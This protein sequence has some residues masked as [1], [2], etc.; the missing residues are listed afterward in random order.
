MSDLISIFQE[1][2]Q[3]R[4]RFIEARLDGENLR[5]ALKK[6]LVD[7]CI[8]DPAAELCMIWLKARI[9]AGMEPLADLPSTLVAQVFAGQDL[10]TFDADG[11]R[12]S[13]SMTAQKRFEAMAK[14]RD[15]EH[16]SESPGGL[17][18]RW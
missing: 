8:D 7:H 6:V 4:G 17:H 10:M 1:T 14:V 15:G 12:C 2:E 13:F 5:S 3:G 16:A 11:K 9:A 18:T